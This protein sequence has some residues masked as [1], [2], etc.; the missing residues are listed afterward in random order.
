MTKRFKLRF[1]ENGPMVI[2]LPE[3]TTIRLNGEEHTLEKAKLA[4]CRCGQSQNKP[5]CDGSHKR[6]AS[7]LPRKNSKSYAP[8]RPHLKIKLSGER[9]W[10]KCG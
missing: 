6:W 2:D 5:F 10:L 1:R 7:P 4:L 8:Y 3:G 9:G